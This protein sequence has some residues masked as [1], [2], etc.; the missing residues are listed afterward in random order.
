V[1]YS[2]PWKMGIGPLLYVVGA[3]SAPAQTF[4]TLFNFDGTNGFGPD[5]LLQ[6]R[7]G[8]FDGITEQAQDLTT[9]YQ[10]R[11]QPSALT[12]C[13]DSA[14]PNSGIMLGTDGNHGIP[15]TF[16]LLSFLS[17]PIAAEATNFH[18]GSPNSIVAGG[19]SRRH[20]ASLS[21]AGDCSGKWMG[22]LC[23][24]EAARVSMGAFCRKVS[25]G[26]PHCQDHF[27][28]RISWSITESILC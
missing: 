10:F 9:L 3:I 25:Y 20:K 14:H 12:A 15:C 8:N 18:F 19:V 22:S 26:A 28:V 27:A 23:R 6:A 1:L 11:E 13:T 7:D 5:G 2:N 21:G 4:T 24:G 16:T 17:R